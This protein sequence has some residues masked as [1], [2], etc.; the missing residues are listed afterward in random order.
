[1]QRAERLR[2]RG[3]RARVAYPESARQAGVS[4]TVLIEVV[5]TP[6]GKLTDAFVAQSSE[7]PLLD[8]AAL[9]AAR[10]SQYAQDYV[11]C[12]VGGKYVF[13]FEFSENE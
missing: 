6:A 13:R 4:G 7:N 1:M 9:Q 2:A 10:D 11:N 8:A 12:H 3:E 5:L